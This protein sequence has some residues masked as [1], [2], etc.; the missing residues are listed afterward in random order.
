METETKDGNRRKN[1]KKGKPR[2]DID[3]TGEPIFK[4]FLRSP[5]DNRPGLGSQAHR[6]SLTFNASDGKIKMRALFPSNLSSEIISGSVQNKGLVR[7][8][9]IPSITF[10]TNQKSI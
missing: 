4:F 9:S 1:G 7:I 5:C 3:Y 10:P 2:C 8:L 6:Q